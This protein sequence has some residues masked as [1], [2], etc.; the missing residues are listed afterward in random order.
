MNFTELYYKETNLAQT[1][2]LLKDILDKVE[3]TGQDNL[4]N[5]QE[6]DKI[7]TLVTNTDSY[8]LDEFLNHLI[9]TNPVDNISVADL[10]NMLLQNEA[11]QQNSL[12][13]LFKKEQEKDKTF[14]AFKS[15]VEQFFRKHEIR[16]KY[17]QSLRSLIMGV[18]AQILFSEARVLLTTYENKNCSVEELVEGL[19]KV[20]TE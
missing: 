2:N 15:L 1:V 14:N 3:E 10:V 9:D 13:C 16:S 20:L 19:C 18:P 12:D 7:H 4:I 11:D 8:E 5:I 6:N 17:P